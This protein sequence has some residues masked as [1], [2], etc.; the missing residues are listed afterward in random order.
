MGDQVW[1]KAN[2]YSTNW[3]AKKL[4]HK[5]LGPFSIVKVISRAV[6]K[7]LLSPREKGVH[8]MVSV[9]NIC[10]QPPDKILEHPQPSLPGPTLV[11]GQEEY[12]VEQVLDS[13]FIC[14]RLYYYVKWEGYPNSENSWIPIE[15]IEHAPQ[16]LLNFH[17][18]HPLAPSL[19]TPSRHALR[20]R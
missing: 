1:L 15:N 10:L 17:H 4:D 14:R 6:V 3:P 11:H 13:N 12:E 16:L 5:W 7:L 19:T 2:H 20:G 9:T 8:P 18:S